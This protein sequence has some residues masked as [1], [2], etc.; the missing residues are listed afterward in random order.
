MKVKIKKLVN[1]KNQSK[2]VSNDK[3]CELNKEYNRK[4]KN[5]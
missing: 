2:K 1:L 3:N 5:I 4:E